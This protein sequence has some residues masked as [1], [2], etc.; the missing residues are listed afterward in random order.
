[1][2]DI[3]KKNKSLIVR[4]TW[5]IIGALPALMLWRNLG[6]F[7]DE[8]A[9]AALARPMAL[10]VVW[11]AAGLWIFL[12]GKLKV[13][14]KVWVSV[15]L[16]AI[17]VWVIFDRSQ[18][19]EV[20][21][22]LATISLWWMAGAFLVK[23]TGMAATVWRW[24]VLLEAQEL[25]VPLRHL[26]GTFLIGRFV[27]SFLPST[28]GL[29]GYRMY[30][31][32]RHSGQTARSVS[33]IVV[34]KV[35]GFFV[36]SA[37]VVGT[38][39]WGLSF[40]REE[41]GPMVLIATAVVF[42]VPVTFSFVMLLF[43]RLIRR[44]FSRVLPPDTALGNKVAKAVKA[45]TAYERNR[46]ALLKAV[47]IGFIVHL[48][49]TMMYF[50]TAHSIGVNVGLGEV[51]YVGPLMI[52]ATVVPISV[53]GIGVREL[54]VSQLMSQVG[55]PAAAAVVFAFLGYLVG[56]II[57]L[58]GGLVLLA[59]RSEYRVVIAGKAMEE[60]VEEDDDELPEPAPIPA[61]E[62]PRLLD[63]VLTGVG[64]GMTAGLL[65]GIAEASVVVSQMQP[66]RDF[67]VLGWAAVV[68]GLIWGLVGGAMASG[69]WLVARLLK[70]R[71]AER[72]RRYAFIASSLFCGFGFVVSWFRIYRDLF[73]EQVRP[74]DPMGL[75][76]LVGL[77]AG[78]GLL[79]LGLRW[80]LHKLTLARGGRFLLRPW[81]TP[82][83]A[84]SAAALLVIFGLVLGEDSA[85]ANGVHGEADASRPNVVL[86]M[87]DTLR[88]DHLELYGH[89]EETA[90]NLTAFAEESVLFTNAF[91]QASWTRPSV[92]TILTGRY[93]SSHNATTKP[94][95][96]PD[97]VETLSEVL[98]EE[99]Y[100]TG[101]VVTNFNLAPY[102]NFHQGF[103]H[104]TFLEPER[105]LWADDNGAKLAIYEL[106]RRVVTRIPRPLEP[107]QFYQPAEVAT[108]EGLRWLRTNP[109]EGAPYFLFLSYMDPH[110]PY[111]RRPLDGTAVGRAFVPHPN[112]DQA[113]EL[114]QLYD[115][116]IR[117][118][119]QHFGRLIEAL[120]Q[121]PDWDRT[122]VIVCADHGEEF[123]DH[124]GWYHGVT[125]Y[126]E[127]LRVPLL[128]RLPGGELGGTRE[129]RWVGLIDIAPT[130][131]RLAGATVP[132]GMGQG[133]DL[134]VPSQDITARQMFAEEDHEGNVLRSV[135][136]RDAEEEW[137]LIEANANNR[138]GL[139]ELELFETHDDPGEQRNLVE[140]HPQVVRQADT[141]LEAAAERAREGAAERSSV[142]LTGGVQEQLRNIGYIESDEHPE[143]DGDH[144]DDQ[145]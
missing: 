29:D 99:G 62:R 104:Y 88:A 25:K 12:K 18:T 123:N 114:R 111:F 6:H 90:P 139:P 72:S 76:T 56:E 121:R 61:S 53:A 85:H 70:L 136:Y 108:D 83:A 133:D 109:G 17:L 142:D 96:L 50:F 91:S 103:D 116:E 131:V 23:G 39:P 54:V 15:G 138:R 93:P 16:M 57:S 14:A 73:H 79:F 11:I 35:I 98:R 82:L 3:L 26:I 47:A 95:A 37:L 4:L 89:D 134:F 106:L 124:G 86:V 52:A 1:M 125:L 44:I 137:K 66:P 34:E 144:S 110:D 43:P 84:C 13:L 75:M 71:R 5:L 78:F 143:E 132:E 120:R 58:F 64:G 115:G 141:F 7:G 129:E 8:A 33:V 112:E 128:V 97:E 30:D 28:V 22:R 130:A 80:L 122:I 140:E 127:Q 135:R 49:T 42:S 81:G 51:L 113:D 38:I 9:A 10:T 27:G 107:E 41:G 48:G 45:V 119:D 21:N 36:L 102:F 117:H 118:W 74:R 31:I 20:V 92:A 32:A 69:F 46:R 55:H 87:V 105:L 63:Y 126:D 145:E 59:R 40:F 94:D 24:K 60:D 68:S 67:T 2:I 100:V 101:G 65:L 19:E 77:A